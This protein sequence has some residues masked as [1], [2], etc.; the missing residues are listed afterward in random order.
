MVL[1]L[2]K[3]IGCQ[4]CSVTCK[5][6][7]TT[8]QGI[9]YAWFNNVE[10][11][12][13]IG[14][15]NKWEDQQRYRGGWIKHADG[16]IGLRQGGRLKEVAGI[17]ANPYLPSMSDYYEPF[18]F[19]FA[20]LKN[21]RHKTPPSARPYSV[22][23][24]R[25]MKKVDSGP[26]WEDDLGGE[27]ARRSAD[28]DLEGVDDVA[29]MAEFERTFMMWL[30]RLCEHCLNPACVASCPSGAI[31][32]R[33]EDGIVLIN[34]SKC[35]GWRECVSACPYKKVYFNWQRKRSE[36]CI[37]CY[38][39]IENGRPTVCAH[40][41]VGRIR[42]IGVVL[43]DQDKI[44]EYASEPDPKLLY[45]TQLMLFLDPNDPE[46]ECK[47]L[48]Q[49]IAREI[50]EA[51]KQSPVYKM[52]CKWRIA[53]PLHPE[54]R[55]LPMTWYVPPLSPTAHDAAISAEMMPDVDDMRIPVRYL[56]NILTAGDPEP[57]RHS[58][59]ALLAVRRL[60]RARAMGQD[61]DE[62]KLNTDLCVDDLDQI[63]RLLAIADY[64][65]RF[66]IP[67]MRVDRAADPFAEH[68]QLG[69]SRPRGHLHPYNYFG[70][71]RTQSSTADSREP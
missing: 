57:V 67:T 19:D 29:R 15:P 22:I 45:Q 3:C 27:F 30:P 7:W 13:G 71:M 9:E 70:G 55:T 18:T 39:R 12:P 50:I 17:F 64:D 5:N 52:M 65:D 31:Y 8:R 32:K 6:V 28:P 69:F 59:N 40:S 54:W 53:L 33:D 10:T 24:G 26:N 34:E 43:Y 16:N 62:L 68:S 56:A 66:V 11:K 51:A 58:L 46:V 47:A 48:G 41:C 61:T 37:F 20:S 1:N 60:Q 4:T 35:R 63:Y 25:R 21:G 49:G 2:D 38:P 42:Y 36:K 23:T 14:Y 44:G